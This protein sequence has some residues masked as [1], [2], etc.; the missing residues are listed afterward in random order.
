MKTLYV[1]DLDG[2]LLRNDQRTSLYTNKTINRLV[3]EGMLFSYATARSYVTA[4]KVTKGL[5]AEIPLIVYN[6]A[7][8][9][10][11]KTGKMIISN[12]FDSRVS[13]VIKDLINNNIYPM[14]YSFIDGIEKMSFVKDKCS[15]GMKEHIKSRKGDKR[16]NP[17]ENQ[18]GLYNGDIFYITC[19]DDRNKLEPLYEKYRDSY[20]C[21]FQQDIYTNEQWLEIMPVNAS[22]AN[23]IKELKEYSGCDKLVVFGDGI[24]DIDMFEI[25]DE[26]YAVENAVNELKKIATR[27]ID[28]NNN[29]GVAKWLENH[30]ISNKK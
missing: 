9:I 7:F 26:C 21:I 6:G 10:N 25:S 22:K 14:V 12:F 30:F 17:L 18:N 16:A 29:D 23:A 27:I 5:N 11:N 1:S 13:A 19:I 8:V 20:H 24:N 15:I 28:S 3:K 4:Q 2:T